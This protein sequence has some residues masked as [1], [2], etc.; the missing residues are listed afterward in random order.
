MD[1]ARIFVV[2]DG[3]VNTGTQIGAEGLVR[4][5]VV[6]QRQCR[7]QQPDIAQAG[8][9][10]DGYIMRSRRQDQLGGDM[11]RP[12]IGDVEFRNDRGVDVDGGTAGQALIFIRNHAHAAHAQLQVFLAETDDGRGSVLPFARRNTT[13]RR[14]SQRAMITALNT[15][16]VKPVTTSEG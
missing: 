10:V 6:L 4:G 15:P 2:E 14:A 7:R 5:E 9:G 11:V 16:I 3:V 1:N 13:P 12:E 8:V